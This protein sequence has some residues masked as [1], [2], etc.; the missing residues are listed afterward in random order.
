MV[1]S[2]PELSLE[3]KDPDDV[4]LIPPSEENVDSVAKEEVMSGL[5]ESSIS[6]ASSTPGEGNGIGVIIGVRLSETDDGSAEKPAAG[7][8][9]NGVFEQLTGTE[10]V[11]AW[12]A[13]ANNRDGGE[14]NEKELHF[15]RNVGEEKAL[16]AERVEQNDSGLIRTWRLMERCKIILHFS[17]YRQ[18]FRQQLLLQRVDKC[19]KIR[20][21]AFRGSLLAVRLMNIVEQIKLDSAQALFFIT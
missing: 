21:T 2:P 17:I 6:S 20:I 18:V 13:R 14:E 5:V 12:E 7:A 3:V 4:V 8:S 16:R 9:V 19:Y 11:N 15:D 1:T 10:S